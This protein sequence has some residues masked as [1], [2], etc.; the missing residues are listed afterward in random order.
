VIAAFILAV[1]ASTLSGVVHDTSGGVVAGAAVIVK[2]STGPERQT[3]T[4]PDGRFTLDAPDTGD[5]T[6]IVRAGGFGER[7]QKVGADRT[8]DL[9]IVVE[10]AALLETVTVTPSRSEQR[11]GE[12]PASVNVLRSEDIKLSPAVVADDV[13]RQIPTFSLFRRTS[14]LSSHPTSQGV[15]LR[16]IGPSGVSR[17]LVLIDGVPFNDPFGGWVYWTRVPL[18]SV[19]RIEVVDGSNSSLY[20]NYAMGGVINIVGSR[21]TRRTVELKP[22]YGNRK[23]PK[24]DFFGS[25]VWGKVGVSAEGSL[26]DTDGFPIVIPAERGV[27]D[28]NA[29]VQFK[30]VNVKVN[31]RPTDR[32]QAFVRTGYF[33]ETRGNGKIDEVNDTRWKSVNGGVRIRLPDESDLQATLFA[34]VE[35]FHSTFLAVSAVNAI[36]RSAVRLTLDQRVPTKSVGGMLQWGRAI[37]TKQFISGG[38]DWRWVDGDSNEDA[39]NQLGPLVSPVTQAVLALKR[40]SG[41]T[42]RSI[43]AFAQD[44][45]TPTPK[46][47]LTLAVR[48]DHWRSYDAHNNETNIPA[49]TPGAGDRPTLP[50][51]VSSVASPR[52]AALYHLTDRVNVWG[53]VSS[54]FRAPTLNELYRQF[55]V[56]TTLTLANFDL[57]PERLIGGEGGVSV[58][59]A[60]NLLFRVTAYDNSVKN[61]VF[62]LTTSIVGVNVTQQ[63]QNVARTEIRGS[64]TD[65]DYRLGAWKI[66][67][68]YMHDDAKVKEI[69][70]PP[71]ANIPSILGND[72]AQVPK[73]RGSFHVTYAKARFATV[74]FGV[75]AVGTQFDDDLNTPSRLLPRYAVADLTASRTIVKN[76]DVF[77]GIQ[78]LFDKEYIVQT[79]PTTVGSP[80]L[81]SGGA[82]VRFSGR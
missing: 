63:R 49:G 23:S 77:V 20:G 28:N 68:G 3:V 79:L 50:E 76:F 40:I 14:S 24:L 18:E 10:P 31:Y 72:L 53:A 71:A 58:A 48:G 80:R 19:D 8:G 15:S 35:D 26:F 43:G 27:I 29:T 75:Q 42:Q 67:G 81:V 37:G 44:I 17:T 57:E 11:L 33:T 55:R 9:N 7:V 22:Q 38:A 69:A 4:G 6:L 51:K 70:A 47:S 52:A 82:R 25:D 62:N 12:I 66:T 65:I 45:I 13:L 74:G 32:V 61:P 78:N 73:N 34:D 54:G 2:S 56:G 36:P 21:P 1:A 46:L 60:H 41:G 59:L 5:V 39:Y 16:G 64:Q 30:N